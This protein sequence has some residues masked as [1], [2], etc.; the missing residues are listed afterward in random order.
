MPTVI[1]ERTIVKTEV[2]EARGMGHGSCHPQLPSVQFVRS[3]FL[4]VLYSDWAQPSDIAMDCGMVRF[5]LLAHEPHG[6]L[7]PCIKLFRVLIL[8]LAL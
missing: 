3:G 6:K 7:L 1:S 8:C 5:A 4:Q 2:A